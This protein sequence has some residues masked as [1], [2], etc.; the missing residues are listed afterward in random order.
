MFSWSDYYGNYHGALL[1][2]GSYY[3]FDDP[4]GTGTRADG[5]ND[6]NLIVGRF[7]QAG[8]T[9]LYDGFKGIN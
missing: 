5:I 6:S 8:S 7:L 9:T 3:I 4:N 1:N 2:A